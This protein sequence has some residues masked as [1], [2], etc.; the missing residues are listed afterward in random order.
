MLADD[1]ESIRRSGTPRE[2]IDLEMAAKVLEP[3]QINTYIKDRRRAGLE[4][5]AMAGLESMTAAAID[6]RLVDLEPKPG[7]EGYDD[8][9][10]VWDKLEKRAGELEK[11]RIEDPALAAD[12]VP[13]V[14]AAAKASLE[15]GTPEAVQ[16][17]IAAR[18]EAQTKFGLD[19]ESRAPISRREAKALFRRL[20]V[21]SEK[22][23]RKALPG[24]VDEIEDRFG[25]F[26]QPVLQT[27]MREAGLQADQAEL[28]ASAL[29]RAVRGGRITPYDMRKV[30][31]LGDA[32]RGLAM[33]DTG[34]A[35][36]GFMSL[37]APEGAAAT[38]LRGG[39][40]A[41]RS[42]LAPIEMTVRRA[43]PG[44]EAIKALKADP[45]RA[46]E[47]EAKYGVPASKYLK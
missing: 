17:L 40:G 6:Q 43:A 3:N 47:F 7:E 41:A 15:A 39:P 33:F 28:M 34:A 46:G 29:T 14:R 16:A 22:E 24:F 20:D 44:P 4:Y 32:A 27:V 19:P 8:K 30:S 1:V 11:L 21:L 25:V 36:Q 12:E 10:Y 31:M 13:E 26:A 23:Y 2:G 45:T 42:G 5:E 9:A 35:D 18:L 38:M 37:Y